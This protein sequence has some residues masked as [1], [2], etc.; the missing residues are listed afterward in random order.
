[1]WLNIPLKRKRKNVIADVV[2]N[3]IFRLMYTC[4]WICSTSR[5]VFAALPCVNTCIIRV[6]IDYVW[7][8]NVL[9]CYAAR[10][11]NAAPFFLSAHAGTTVDK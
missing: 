9:V 7:Y 4:I 2:Y 8:F 6:A 1:M 3:D 5:Y 11:I 10:A